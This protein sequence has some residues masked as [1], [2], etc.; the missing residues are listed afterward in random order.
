MCR[1]G[2][3]RTLQ[4]TTKPLQN[5][6]EALQ[7]TATPLQGTAETLQETA[8]SLQRSASTLRDK[9][10][11]ETRQPKYNSKDDHPI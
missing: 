6:N 9:L 3:A 2:P 11:P 10:G 5:T 1:K 4:T 8:N 7:E